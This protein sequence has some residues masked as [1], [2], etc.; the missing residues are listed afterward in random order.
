MM[1]E[2]RMPD[3]DLT[4]PKKTAGDHAHA[5]LRVVLNAVPCLGSAAAAFWSHVVVTP[6]ERRRDEW[7]TG[8]AERLTALTERVDGLAESLAQDPVFLDTLVHASTVALRTSQ[9]EKL[10]ALRNAVLNSALPG[11]PESA[12]RLMFLNYIDG[13]T[14]WHIHV[15][16]LFTHDREK[17]TKEYGVFP[18]NVGQD[19]MLSD[20]VYSDLRDRPYLRDQ[21]LAD[22]YARGL[23]AEPKHSR[24]NDPSRRMT[25]WGR[26]FLKFI[27]EPQQ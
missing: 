22:L 27:E 26:E 21:V 18:G 19:W 12:V 2:R 20:A 15:L 4:P 16:R 14:E 3:N 25:P 23:L 8:I 7:R 6:L 5:G 9:E 1:E 13:F 24:S 10:K 17:F 11:A